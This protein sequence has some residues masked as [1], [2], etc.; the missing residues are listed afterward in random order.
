M[1]MLSLNTTSDYY[2]LESGKVMV[3]YFLANA[4]GWRGEH[5]RRIK[6]ELTDMLK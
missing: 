2:C 1:A 5:A 4:K 3:M 6:A